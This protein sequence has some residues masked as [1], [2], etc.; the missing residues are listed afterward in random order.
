[1]RAVGLRIASV[2]KIVLI[3]LWSIIFL[4]TFLFTAAFNPGGTIMLW[5]GR[6][7]WSPVITR[8]VGARLEVHGEEK[9]DSE[10]S[11]VYVSNHISYL[12]PPSIAQ[13]LPHNIS[14][15]AKKELTRIPLFG[16]SIRLARMIII[17]RSNPAKAYASLK[18]AGEV[19]RNGLSVLVF[20]EG[21]RSRTGDLQPFKKGAFFLAI[22]AGVPIAPIVVEGSQ[23][24]HR[25]GD[26]K[27][28]SHRVEIH[29]LDPIDTT[30]YTQDQVEELMERVQGVIA[31]EQARI[32]G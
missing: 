5:G 12:D 19:I 26:W 10:K 27:I 14:F 3:V 9:L 8:I 20:A 6:C 16:A 30:G 32:R 23:Y 18:R 28:A 11:Y 29:F 17:D 15:V 31:T 7:V 21:T 1:M 22:E 2:I 4:T 25:P 24:T 13:K